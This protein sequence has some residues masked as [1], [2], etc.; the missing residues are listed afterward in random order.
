M[1]KRLSYEEVK[2]RVEKR[3][4]KLISTEYYRNSDKL[5]YKCPNN[6]TYEAKFND[7]CNGHGCPYCAGL[8][9]H[10]YE[11]I[12]ENVEKE[13]YY[14]ISEN[15]KNAKQKLVMI[16]P[17]SHKCE[18]NWNNFSNGFRCR[19]CS[20]SKGEKRIA[21][22]LNLHNINYVQQYNFKECRR[23]FPL[24]FDFY[25][26]SANTCIE[27]DGEQHF[28]PI[29]FRG[30]SEQMVLEQFEIT[31]ECDRI[32]NEYC[33]LNSINLIRIPYAK[34]DEIENILTQLLI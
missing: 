23:V 8:Y 1:S 10:S 6:H 22:F 2:A 18:I 15:Y 34:F 5:K 7:F 12:K 13:G 20:E 25:I 16:C 32:K 26:S 19:K 4:F 30:M 9:R 33:D 27:Y 24:P 28:K 11:Y 3:G 14:L 21:T 17:K 29:K 31:K